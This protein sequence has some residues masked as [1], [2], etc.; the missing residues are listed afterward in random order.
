MNPLAKLFK[1]AQ[2]AKA[3][4]NAINQ[5]WDA[6][7]NEV[8]FVVNKYQANLGLS[9]EYEMLAKQSTGKTGVNIL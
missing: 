7:M 2:E 1:M 3:S 9:S 5:E 6:Y 8:D 4:E